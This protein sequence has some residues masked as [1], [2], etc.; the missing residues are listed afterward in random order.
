MKLNVITGLPRSGSTLLTNI[1]NQ[2]PKFF[3][4]STSCVPQFVNGL[5]FNWSN[6][7]EIKSMLD[8]DPDATNK[9][10]RDTARATVEAWYAVENKEIIFDK[11][12]A[13]ASSSLLLQD[14]FPEAKIIVTVRDLRNV[15]ASVE[16]QHR[17][18]PILDESTNLIEKTI[19]NRADKMFSAE[20][21]IGAPILGIE[22]LAR[23]KPNGVIYVMYESFVQNP[24]VVM[25]RIYQEIGESPF[26]HDFDNVV[27]TS[28]DPDG[29]YLNKYPH[30]GEGKVEPG[31][32][33]EWK[34]Y[35]SPDLGNTIMTRFAD[36]NKFF[37]YTNNV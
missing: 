20:G 10:M 9:R 33:D 29:F 22:D 4:S 11:S 12:R 30:K 2:N 19:Y 16:K 15:F 25:D 35:L 3:A 7:I 37:G 34:K 36:F 31:D 32:P 1:L 18:N 26:D 17:K 23:R 21:L 13:W 27:N 5:S 24:Q 8:K 28:T 14:I 6:S